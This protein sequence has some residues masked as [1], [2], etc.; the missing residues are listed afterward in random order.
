MEQARFGEDRLAVEVDVDED[1]RAMLVPAFM[2]QPLVENSVKHAMPAEGKLTIRI[3]GEMDGD[4]VYLHVSDAV[5][6]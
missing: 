2:V 5:L 3:A 1:V 6:V 4:D